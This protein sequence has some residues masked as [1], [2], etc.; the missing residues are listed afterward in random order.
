MLSSAL[1]WCDK[2]Q[3]HGAA[4]EELSY[5]LGVTL[6]LSSSLF[7]EWKCTRWQSI[8][9]SMA[10]DP[11]SLTLCNW[12]ALSSLYMPAVKKQ[13]EMNI[14]SHH[15]YTSKPLPLLWFDIPNS[16]VPRTLNRQKRNQRACPKKG[17]SKKAH[18]STY[19]MESAKYT[20]KYPLLWLHPSLQQNC[21][22]AV[23]S[24]C[25]IVTVLSHT[26]VPNT[27]N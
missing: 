4:S 9:V 16:S 5:V 14:S 13:N 17:L 19:N 2:R 24:D 3:R 1:W 6:P 25:P 23:S 20:N 27:K 8:P 10:S 18:I 11:S 7:P 21:I 15:I 26:T 22:N 12:T